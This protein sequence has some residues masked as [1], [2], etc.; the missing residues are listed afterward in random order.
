MKI[1]DILLLSAIGF[2]CAGAYLYA[3]Y[4]QQLLLGDLVLIQNQYVSAIIFIY[5]SLK[6]ENRGYCNL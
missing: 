3:P 1:A 5:C 4:S 2:F 6:R